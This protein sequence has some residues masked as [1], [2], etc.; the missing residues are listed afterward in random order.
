M[1]ELSCESIPGCILQIYVWLQNPEETGTFALLSILISALTT[2]YTSAMIAFDFDVDVPHRKV[3]PLF[4]GFI[5][6]DHALRSRCFV[7]MTLISTLHNLSR[8]VACALLAIQDKRLMVAFF[9]GEMGLYLLFKIVRRDFLY[10]MRIDGIAG[11]IASFVMRFL[12]K[13][14]VDFSG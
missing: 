9:G 12:V 6:N 8:S 1:F 4:Y 10:W 13:V 5:P 2:G 11:V 3:Y 14:I 7:L